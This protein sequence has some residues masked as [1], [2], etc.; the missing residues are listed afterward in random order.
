[1]P[2]ADWYF[3]F[4][5]PFS[6]LQSELLDGLPAA[7]EIEYRPLLFAG[8]LNHWGH[9]GPAEMPGKRI[10][11]F[12]YCRWWAQKH[13]I[14]FIMP[15]AHPFNPLG[16]LRL[17]IA[18]GNAPEAVHGIYRFIWREGRAVDSEE[19]WAAL[20]ES[21]GL[22]DAAA[23]I[24]APEVKDALR[25][26]GEEAIAAGVFGVPSFVLDGHIFWGVEATD[27]LRD[28]LADPGMFDSGEMARISNL[29]AGIER[30][31]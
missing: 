5:S 19:G 12:R 25:A 6:Y 14:P 11:T 29:P 21:L 28:Y 30:Q 22:E 26:N 4:I 17:A 24:A 18:A 13:G 20:V 9:K 27:M 10:Y 16:V 3:D 8:L 2:R 15:P 7:L 1:M 31:T 23:R